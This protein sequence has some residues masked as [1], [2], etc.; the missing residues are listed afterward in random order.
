MRDF[1]RP[2]FRSL[3][4]PRLFALAALTVLAPIALGACATTAA[5][6]VP[7]KQEELIGS[8]WKLLVMSGRMDHRV[9]QF[10]NKE[11]RLVGT[12]IN[13]G[14]YLSQIVGVNEGME[15]F[16]ISPLEGE[17]ATYEGIFRTVMSDGRANE[18][19]VTIQ[20]FEDHFTWNLESATWERVVE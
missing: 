17:P 7:L 10:E 2:F 3:T 11:G 6:N 18:N 15:M 4:V 12:L 5:S 20:F 14:R 1:K 13:R 19:P 8:K 16:A 9:V